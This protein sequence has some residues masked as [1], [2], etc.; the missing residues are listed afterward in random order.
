M[1]NE[2]RWGEDSTM[3]CDT[4][5]EL[6]SGRILEIHSD[7]KMNFRIPVWADNYFLVTDTNL[8]MYNEAVNGLRILPEMSYCEIGPGL[9]EFIPEVV[10][11]L[12]GS[13]IKPTA[14]DCVNYG[15]L[16]KHLE[17]AKKEEHLAERTRAKNRIDV[18]ISRAKIVTNPEKVNFVN[19][20]LENA[21]KER[22]ELIGKMDVVVDSC[23]AYFYVAESLPIER[24]QKID[25]D[26]LREETLSLEKILLKPN[27]I[28]IVNTFGSY[29]VINNS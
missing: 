8:S 29:R 17:D 9:G 2:Y 19:L 6:N 16:I 7:R 18:L 21:I 10:S 28:L 22:P 4:F 13:G 5:T 26:A 3:F 24:R 1:E 15:D 27:G 20:T 14:I 12:Q 11:A 23:G 25:M